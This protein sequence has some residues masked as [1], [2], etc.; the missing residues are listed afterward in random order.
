MKRRKIV[1][2]KTREQLAAEY[3]ISTKTLKKWLA[4]EN[5]YV[6]SRLFT[7]KEMVQIYEILGDR[8]EPAIPQK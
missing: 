4:R 8:P 1:Q 6:K 7:P 2:I 3:G 5:F